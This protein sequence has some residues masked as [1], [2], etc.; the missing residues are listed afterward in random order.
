MLASKCSKFYKPGFNSTWTMNLQMSKPDLENVEETEIKL[1]T[2]VGSSKKQ[3]DSRKIHTSDSLT[4]LKSLTVWITTNYGKFLKR[5]KY[6]TTLPASWET[7][8]QVKKQSLEPNMEQ[9]T[10]SKLGKDYIT[11]EYC[12]P[13]YLL[14][15]S[16]SFFYSEKSSD[17]TMYV[18]CSFARKWNI[19]LHRHS[20]LTCLCIQ[21]FFLFLL[22]LFY[23]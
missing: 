3:E 21:S 14:F 8:M 6:Q 4:M 12:Y 23:F 16:L 5:W 11:A 13:P 19:S 7:C 1:L 10:G 2:S 20:H 17:R 9:Q 18:I 15:F 22:I